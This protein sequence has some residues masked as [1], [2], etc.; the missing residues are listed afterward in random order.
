MRTAIRYGRISFRNVLDNILITLDA[1]SF[2]F[3]V[4]SVKLDA[5]ILPGS[6]CK[7]IA[8]IVDDSRRERVDLIQ[9]VLQRL[10]LLDI[11]QV[12]YFIFH[13][14]SISCEC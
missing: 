10:K 8:F 12:M 6:R 3:L 5:N 14:I 9:P 13:I 4:L 2:T 11:D 1:F 7:D